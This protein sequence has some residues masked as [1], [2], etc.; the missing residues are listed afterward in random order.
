M[1]LLNL[2]R[3]SVIGRDTAATPATPATFRDTCYP[4]VARV[5]TVARVTERIEGPL[6][7][8]A[9]VAMVR[10]AAERQRVD[11][12]RHLL[13]TLLWDAPHEVEPEIGLALRNG[14]LEKALTCYRRCWREY[15]ELE[16][17]PNQ[18]HW[19]NYSERRSSSS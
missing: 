13:K 11:G 12:L 9:T 14:D 16:E 6:A 2:I 5:A 1:S 8:R 19:P 4:T 17:L 10:G 15:H 7:V 3:R 18:R